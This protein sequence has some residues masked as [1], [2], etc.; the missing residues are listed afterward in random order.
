MNQDPDIL[1]FFFIYPTTSPRLN[2]KLLK[3]TLSDKEI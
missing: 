1:P 3:N 2:Y